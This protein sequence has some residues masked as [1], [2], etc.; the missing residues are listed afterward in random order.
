MKKSIFSTSYFAVILLA[1]AMVFQSC[2]SG[3]E[4]CCDEDIILPPDT[5]RVPTV[6]IEEP[7]R[8][9]DYKVTIQIG[10][11]RDEKYANAFYSEAVSKLSMRVDKSLDTRDG[12]FK[13]TVGVFDNVQAANNFLNTVVSAGYRDAFVR[14]LRP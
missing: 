13:I 4:W 12:L 7:R 3:E 8:P 11:F 6:V 5:I 14:T 2:S 10:A 9:V 1:I